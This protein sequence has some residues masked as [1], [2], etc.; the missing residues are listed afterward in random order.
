MQSNDGLILVDS[1]ATVEGIRGA[2]RQLGDRVSQDDLF[3]F[4]YSGH[5]DRQER[6]SIQPSDPDNL[7]E[8]LLL[9]DGSITDDE[10][11]ELC[12]LISA[13]ISLIII[14][15]SFSGG[16]A[17]DVISVPGRVGLFSSQEDVVSSVAVKFRAG[18][19]LA[20]FLADGIGERQADVDGDDQLTASEL[21]EYLENRY[22]TYVRAGGAGDNIRTGGP[23]L[24]YQQFVFER[25]TIGPSVMIL[26]LLPEDSGER[27][28]GLL[29]AQGPGRVYTR[30]PMGR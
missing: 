6:T 22:R 5:G 28:V 2:F 29:G 27:P 1:D 4:F 12:S 30:R 8:M 18:G 24:G 13:R 14:D 21:T 3:V 15:A 23:E 11:G 25:G 17:K 7:D 16:F 26:R 20:P 9:Y 19:F 10:M